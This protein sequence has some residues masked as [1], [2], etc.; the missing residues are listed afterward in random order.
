MAV[1]VLDGSNFVVC[2]QRGDVDGI[3]DASGFFAADT[4]FLSRLVLTVDGERS[5]PVAVEQPAP[6][7]ALFDLSAPVG[8]AVRRELFVGSGLEE[9]I[10]VENRSS[11]DVEAVLGLEVAT[12]FADIHAVKRVADGHAAADAAAARPER[13]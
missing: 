3:A 7:L 2:D 10:T 13:W 11:H 8:L 5:E 9:S 6:H 12:D 4:R 1:T